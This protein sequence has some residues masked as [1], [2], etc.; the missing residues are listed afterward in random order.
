MHDSGMM[1]FIERLSSIRTYS[2][3]Q[4]SLPIPTSA[5]NISLGHQVRNFNFSTMTSQDLFTRYL[6][7]GRCHTFSTISLLCLLILVVEYLHAIMSD[8]DISA[9]WCLTISLYH[10][11]RNSISSWW[12]YWA[13]YQDMHHPLTNQTVL[14]LSVA[15]SPWP[16]LQ[17]RILD[18]IRALQHE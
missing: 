15:M 12:T 7:A 16:D 1:M 4:S 9:D 3:G 18:S 14:L 2:F 8:S 17:Y 10:W 6:L 13:H 5:P 11:R